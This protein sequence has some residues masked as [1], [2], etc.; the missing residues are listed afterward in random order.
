[1]LS[2][3]HPQWYR[4]RIPP[5]TAQLTPQPDRCSGSQQKRCPAMTDE[6]GACRDSDR[7]PASRR[8]PAAK[9]NA[10][11][12]IRR[13][14]LIWASVRSRQSHLAQIQLGP[15][16]GSRLQHYPHIRSS[17]APAETGEPQRQQRLENHSTSRDRL[18]GDPQHQQRLEIHSTSRDWRTT[19]PAETG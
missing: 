17:A 3:G 8:P 6:P 10:I 2:C 9:L 18:T 1:M 12:T 4:S 14:N 15:G 7:V 11:T 13:G 5:S 19:A 16:T